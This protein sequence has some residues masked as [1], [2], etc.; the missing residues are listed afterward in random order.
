MVFNKI[1]FL[2]RVLKITV[3]K[4]TVGAF[5][6]NVYLSYDLRKINCVLVH[7]IKTGRSE[8]KSPSA[9]IRTKLILNNNMFTLVITA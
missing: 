4:T 8:T 7:R 5:K 2:L 9:I 6:E 1:K 3:G